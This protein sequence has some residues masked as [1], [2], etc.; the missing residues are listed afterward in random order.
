MLTVLEDTLRD[1]KFELPGR[2]VSALEIDAATV[3]DP[4]TRLKTLLE[5][6]G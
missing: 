4:Q 3:R 1:F 2:G 5:E 6:C